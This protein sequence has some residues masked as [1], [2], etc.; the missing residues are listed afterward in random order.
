LVEKGCRHIKFLSISSSLPI[1]TKRAQGFLDAM[2]DSGMEGS[3]EDLIYYC[4]GTPAK[5]QEQIRSFLLNRQNTD[6]IVASVER[7]AIQVY[8]S[9]QELSIKIPSDIKIIA[10]STVE[11]APILNPSLST[12]TQPAFEIGKNAADILFTL[13]NGKD[14]G[15][16]KK[17][18]IIPSVLIERDSTKSN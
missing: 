4:T 8:L 9:C 5:T 7:L 3:E 11:T 14:Y 18:M 2:K 13:M 12:I 15:Y 6:G 10:F 17:P 16:S 1:C